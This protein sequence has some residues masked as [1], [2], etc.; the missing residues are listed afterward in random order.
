MP[1]VCTPQ[2]EEHGGA[3]NNG[4]SMFAKL[5]GMRYSPDSKFETG[6]HLE[7]IV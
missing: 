7:G 1:V 6:P 4:H 2:E 5:G 3:E